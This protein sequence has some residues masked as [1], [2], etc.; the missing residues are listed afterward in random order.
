VSSSEFRPPTP[1]GFITPPAS[2]RPVVYS[3]D[4]SSL[5][6]ISEYYPPEKI[7]KESHFKPSVS[8]PSVDTIQCSHPQNLYTTINTEE[9]YTQVSIPELELP[10]S[11][12]HSK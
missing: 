7:W 8:S 1:S 9:A 11:S 5:S 12:S 10:P 6:D 3:F 4:N 2:E